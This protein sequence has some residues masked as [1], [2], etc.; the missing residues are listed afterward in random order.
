M[1]DI[2]PAN[3]I[4]NFEPYF[5]ASLNQR[6]VELKEN[7]VDII[8]LDMGSPDLPPAG[9]IID[10]L[11]SEVHRSDAHGY[12]PNGGTLAYRKAIA[13]Y[14]E[15]RFEVELDPDREIIGLIGSKEGLF[16]LSQ[17]L[18]NPGDL[19]F[20]PDPAYPVYKASGIIA[21][22]D[23]YP[24]PLLPENGF[25]PDLDAIP[26]DAAKKG[27]LLWLNYPNNP[28]GAVAT[29][30]F[31]EKVI[32]MA[33]R[34]G[35]VIAHDAPYSDVCFDGYV[36]PSILQIPGAKQIAVEFNSLSKA[37]NM[38]GWRLGM[39]VGNPQVISYLKTYKSQMDSSHFGPIL[40]AGVKALT[41]DQSWIQERNHIYQERRDIV[42]RSLREARFKVSVPP[43]A[44]YV[45]AQ[46]P[47]G[48][49]D[50]TDFC[51]HLLNDTGVST[52]PGVVYGNY[53]EGFIR[54]SLGTDTNKI[55]EAMQRLGTWIRTKNRV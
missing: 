31:F 14:Y 54:I 7:G 24:L 3:R 50:S 26:E 5:F 44:I 51:L 6:L 38:A 48:E 2:I 43:A 21:G 36:A 49:R 4:A 46:L 1:M 40:T 35:W 22:A 19:V 20:V 42:V 34:Y 55:T 29:L 15:N 11:V 17:V 13:T 41:S 39:A 12:T 10:T 53:G 16:N 52:T 28:T 37:Y 8:R 32:L 47:E 23:I 27:K 45:W 33:L 9:F 25:L 18:I 30:H